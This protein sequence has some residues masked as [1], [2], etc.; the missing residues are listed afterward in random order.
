MRKIFLNLKT[1]SSQN[2]TSAYAPKTITK[3]LCWCKEGKKQRPWGLK[4]QWGYEEDSVA[5]VLALRPKSNCTDRGTLSSHHW[6]IPGILWRVTVVRKP[7]LLWGVKCK[8]VLSVMGLTEV[9]YEMPLGLWNT[10]KW[11]LMKTTTFSRY[12]LDTWLPDL[13]SNK[14]IFCHEHVRVHLYHWFHPRHIATNLNKKCPDPS[15]LSVHCKLWT[16]HIIVLQLLTIYKWKERT[17]VPQKTNENSDTLRFC[18][19]IPF[20]SLTNGGE[21]Q[22]FQKYS[23][24]HFQMFENSG[25]ALLLHTR[26]KIAEPRL[27]VPWALQ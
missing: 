9:L 8:G 26:E 4:P 10:I 20:D 22:M 6:V 2:I 16:Y 5:V 19:N 23:A 11:G 14:V 15:D 24:E 25:I 21:T 13:P 3:D 12:V 7:Q 1:T 27:Q 17:N 18:L